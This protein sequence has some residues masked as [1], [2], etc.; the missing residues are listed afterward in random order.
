MPR[1]LDTLRKKLA[2]RSDE[3]L[4]AERAEL[5]TERAEIAR[6][7]ARCREVSHRAVDQSIERGRAWLDRQLASFAVIQR[8]LEAQPTGPGLPPLVVQFAAAAALPLLA[9]TWH[10]LVDA[11][12]RLCDTPLVEL[13]RRSDEIQAR[14]REIRVEQE[15][16]QIAAEI[17]SLEDRE[18][19]LEGQVS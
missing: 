7:R 18:R 15:R 5:Q 14:I 1:V 12:G 10:G 17:T 9:E 6:D 3:R 4:E 8:P 2:E 19:D 13:E 11:D 16:R